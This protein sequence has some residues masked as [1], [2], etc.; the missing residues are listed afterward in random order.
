[1]KAN[2]VPD[3]CTIFIDRRLVPGEDPAAAVAEM[4]AVAEEA[5]AGQPGITVTV[6]PAYEGLPAT[7]SDPDGF[8]ARAM[9]AANRFLG[10]STELTGFSMAT[11]GRHFAAAGFP[12][13]HLRPG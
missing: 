10:L 11:D 6:D 2:V 13:H 3:R 8:L 7:M 5:I 4:R 1:M 12:D 9:L